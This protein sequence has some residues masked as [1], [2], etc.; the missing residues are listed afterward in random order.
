MLHL[1]AATGG[2]EDDNTIISG[3]RHEG[4][5]SLVALYRLRPRVCYVSSW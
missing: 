3:P 1:V 4:K 5:G 2:M